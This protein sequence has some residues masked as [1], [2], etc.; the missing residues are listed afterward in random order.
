MGEAEA[1]EMEATATARSSASDLPPP[2]GGGGNE[3]LATPTKGEVFEMALS[4]AMQPS[5]EVEQKVEALIGALDAAAIGTD[6]ES[7]DDET[8]GLATLTEGVVPG[9]GGGGIRMTNAD[10]IPLRRLQHLVRQRL[11]RR[12]GERASPIPIRSRASSSAA[13]SRAASVHGG[14]FREEHDE[15]YAGHVPPIISRVQRSV[16]NRLASRRTQLDSRRR[17]ALAIERFYLK[18]RREPYAAVGALPPPP[19]ATAPL[20]AAEEAILS[21]CCRRRR[22]AASISGDQLRQL[23]HVR[24]A[25]AQFRAAPRADPST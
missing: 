16:R 7:D 6:D 17:A 13:S 5:P 22:G 15:H 21:R 25:Q 23:R 18:R 19:R 24:A 1:A 14:S 20:G 11:R 10:L 8:A 12:V 9:I 2:E 4:L 3:L